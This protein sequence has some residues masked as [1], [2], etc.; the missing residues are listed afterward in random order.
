MLPVLSVQFV[1]EF[2]HKCFSE[3]HRQLPCY[4]SIRRPYFKITCRKRLLN[5]FENSFQ[6]FYGF[7]RLYF[8]KFSKFVKTLGNF[9][10]SLFIC[11]IYSSR[12]SFRTCFDVSFRNF[13]SNSFWKFL[14]RISS[15]IF[16]EFLENFNSKY[17]RIHTAI[18]WKTPL[19]NPL[20]FSGVLAVFPLRSHAE[21]PLGIPMAL[22][23]ENRSVTPLEIPRVIILGIPFDISSAYS[24]KSPSEFIRKYPS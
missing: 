7:F 17:Y 1:W 19:K 11:F 9:Y 18:D 4:S 16:R 24:L 2:F 21:T 3:F 14:R 13:I 20:F 23:L 12:V 8:R 10:G 15:R 6:N 5:Y 22:S